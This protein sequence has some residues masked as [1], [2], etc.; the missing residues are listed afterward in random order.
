MTNSCS[1]EHSQGAIALPST[2]LRVAWVISRT[3]QRPIS[4]QREIRPGKSFGVGSACPLSRSIRDR[5][6]LLNKLATLNRL[7]DLRRG[8]LGQTHGGR[9]QLLSQLQSEIPDPL[10]ENLPEFL[11][12]RCVRTPTIGLLL[13]ILICEHGLKGP[14]MQIQIQD[15]CRSEGSRRDGGEELLIDDPVAP[16]A[17]GRGRSLSWMRG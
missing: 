17:D 6:I 2:L 16:R 1:I 4:L 15:I 7:I 13:K 5:L 11:S 9:R 8:E 10:R 3:E 12:P 14:A